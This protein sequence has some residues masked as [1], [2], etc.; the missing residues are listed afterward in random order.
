MASYLASG[1]AAVSLRREEGKSIGMHE[2]TNPEPRSPDVDDVAY[3]ADADSGG[4]RTAA[5]ETIH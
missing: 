5:G 4:V 1:Q 2:L 3:S